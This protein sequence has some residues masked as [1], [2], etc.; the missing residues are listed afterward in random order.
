MTWSVPYADVETIKRIRSQRYR[1]VECKR[2]VA[3]RPCAFC[4]AAINGG[5]VARVVIGI[6]LR[7]HSVV[8]SNHG[9]RAGRERAGDADR[10]IQGRNQGIGAVRN[11]PQRDCDDLIPVGVRAC[12]KGLALCRLVV[13][14]VLRIINVAQGA[15]ILASTILTN[16][17]Y[18]VRDYDRARRRRIRAE[19]CGGG[20]HRAGQRAGHRSHCQGFNE[21]HAADHW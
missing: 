8:R 2:A 1:G 10:V 14:D 16:M 4:G 13:S 17:A 7:H 20:L 3:A 18:Q 11:L 5:K 19:R 6:V 9:Q 15:R 21:V 12:R